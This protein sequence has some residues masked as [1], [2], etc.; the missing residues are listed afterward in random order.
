MPRV[1]LGV[2]YDGGDFVGWQMQRGGRSVQGVL[3]DAVGRVAAEPVVLHAAGRTDA[4]VH[5][6]QQVVHFDTRAS[7]L[8]RQWVLGVNSSLP[9]DVRVH[10]AKAVEPEF[11]ARRSATARRYRYL[12]L[13]S[14][15]ESALLRRRVW[16][17]RAE[18]DCAAMSRAALAWLGEQDFSAFRAAGCQSRSP[19]R[20]LASVRVARRP[21]L[22][23]LEFVANAF[24][25]HMVRN[26]VGVLVEI[27]ARR[28]PPDWAGA[29]LAAKDRRAGAMTAPARG[30]TLV[31]VMYPARF[32]IPAARGEPAL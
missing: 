32:E 21:P 29:L 1:A 19:M 23:V 8:P 26:L 27:G 2:E 30:L 7:R 15:T 13:C 14:A 28:A 3:T 10:W 25:H 22:V 4:G 9:R 6:L 11:D 5:A 17:L 24:L 12:I 31:D 20:F 18:L 16:W